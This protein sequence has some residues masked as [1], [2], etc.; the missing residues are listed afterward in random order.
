MSK[1]LTTRIILRNDSTTNWLANENQILL[2]GEVGIEFLANGKVKMKIGDGKS[3][4]KSLAYFGGDEG[5]VFE[6]T[7]SA[8]AN[9][10]SAITTAVGTT[11]ISKGD[12]AII[13]E[14]IIDTSNTEL[15]A[16]LDAGTI[17]QAYQYTAYVYNG[18]SWAAMDGNCSA[19]NVYFD[20]DFTFTTRIGTVQ[21]L[22]NGSTTVEAA[23]KNLKQ[24]LT[25]L[26]AKETHVTSV[27]SND[28]PKVSITLDGAGDYEVGT[29][30]NPSYTT[31]F[32]DG[33]YPNGPEPTGVTATSYSVTSTDGE[34]WTTSSGTCASF[35]VEDN[36]NYSVS[37]SVV[38][39]EGSPALSNMGSPGTYK[40]TAG[41]KNA[42]SEAITGYRKQFYGAQAT[43]IA[44]N[45]TEIRK[46]NSCKP[47]DTY[48]GKFG[49]TQNGFLL[50]VEEGS[51]Q[52]VIALY[53]KTLIDVKDQGFS[54]NSIFKAFDEVSATTPI[55]VAGA[56]NHAALNYNVYVYNSAT[57]LGSN[58]YECIIG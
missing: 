34:T 37:V 31:S 43:P 14:E 52:V 4:W 51:K 49:D 57:S 6:A 56:N 15:E 12:V 20:E 58:T 48:V 46:L 2:K 10:N 24:F 25:G 13:K 38:H 3:T 39:T 53:G 23:G 30:V 19:E 21:T 32:D 44:L 27:S 41:T 54:C 29:T 5:H 40:F 36:E 45:S 35:V 22:T 28:Q 7:V 47:D 42:T 17:S 18:T 55:P 16:K 50:N 26:F 8:G 11:S 33:K 9:H 1:T